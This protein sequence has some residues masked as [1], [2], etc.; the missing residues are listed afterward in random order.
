MINS[1]P[2]EKSQVR[3]PARVLGCFIRN[4]IQL[5]IEAG[6]GQSGKWDLPI[7]D[8]PLELRM[9]NTELDVIVYYP[10]FEITKNYPGFEIIKIVK[11]NELYPN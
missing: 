11:R 6:H 4:E 2:S 7:S 10:G 1:M 8:I 3:I 9:P 5:I